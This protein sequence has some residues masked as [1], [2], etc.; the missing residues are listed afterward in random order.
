MPYPL[1]KLW[2]LFEITSSKRVFKSE[3]KSEW[4]PFYRAREIVKLAKNG[5]VDNDLFI[6]EKMFHEYSEKYGIPKENDIMVTWVWTLWICYLVKNDD[7]FYF[8]DGNIIWLK[9]I[10]KEVDSRYI[11]YGFQSEIIKKQVN[12]TTWTSVWTYT[13]IR[14]KNTKIPLPPL[15]TQKAIVQKLDEAF[16][17]IDASIELAEKNLKEID[18]GNASVLEE[19]FGS[20]QYEEKS[21]EQISENI[22]YWYTWK[23]TSKWKVRYLRITDIQNNTIYW[24]NV[25]FVEI[26]ER[27]ISKYSLNCWDIVFARTG[28]TVWKSCLIDENGIGNIFASYLIR[29]VS[30]LD[31]I[32]PEYLQYFFYSHKYWEQIWLDVVWAAQPNF[33]GTKLKQIKLPLPPLSKQKEIVEYLDQVFAVN[34]ELKRAYE[35]KIHSLK[36]L[37]QS[38]LRGAFEGRLVRE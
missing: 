24:E 7:K 14:A 26:E 15:P 8:K 37:K 4:I 20:G 36:E 17:S 34:A 25:P 6:T 1:K 19:V 10:G 31:L 32:F 30:K 21:V 3:W 22:Q 13:I 29:I 27:E 2:E 33:N 28:A 9:H 35:E 23:T 11:E 12:Q 16:A 18:E 38:L 5:F